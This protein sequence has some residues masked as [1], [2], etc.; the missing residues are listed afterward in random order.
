MKFK[1][2]FGAIFRLHLQGSRI[3]QAR[4]S[5]NLMINRVL[6]PSLTLQPWRCMWYIPLTSPTFFKLNGVTNHRTVLCMWL[7]VTCE[8]NWREFRKKNAI[9]ILNMTYQRISCCKGTNVK[10]ADVYCLFTTELYI[11]IYILTMETW[12]WIR[13]VWIMQAIVVPWVIKCEYS[14]IKVCGVASHVRA[15]CKRPSM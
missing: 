15:G 3:K 8:M 7:Y 11:Y 6:P 1:I 13:K 2:S 4:N 9:R 10:V 14:L 5:V 12:Y